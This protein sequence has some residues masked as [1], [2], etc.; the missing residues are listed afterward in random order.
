MATLSSLTY[1]LN[2][3]LEWIIVVEYFWS[4]S[5]HFLYVSISPSSVLHVTASPQWHASYQ[6]RRR[7]SA[8]PWQAIL[9]G[10]QWC[11]ARIIKSQSAA[12]QELCLR[13][14]FVTFEHLVSVLMYKSVH[15]VHL[16]VEID[17]GWKCNRSSCNIVI[18][19]RFRKVKFRFNGS[20]FV[21]VKGLT[22][23]DLDFYM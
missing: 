21:V 13:I 23:F 8:W 2:F 1:F 9:I 3:Q 4:N 11:N 5:T 10:R 14:S 15:F 12:L 18:F 19:T 7:C 6:L 22:I 17:S 20:L 16:T